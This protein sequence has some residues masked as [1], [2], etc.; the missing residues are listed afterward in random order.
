[1]NIAITHTTT[2]DYS[3]DISESAMEVRLA[4]ASNE[5]QT[6][7]SHQLQVTPRVKLLPYR[8]YFGSTVHFF[9][10]PGHYRRLAVVSTS[11]VETFPTNPFLRLEGGTGQEPLEPLYDYLQFGGPVGRHPELASIAAAFGDERPLLERLTALNQTINRRLD[12][13]PLVT[14]VDSVLD[15]VLALGQGVCQ[16]FAHLMIGVCRELGVPARYVSGYLY[17]PPSAG[18]RGGG[19]SHAWCECYLPGAGWKGFDPT[20]DLLVDDQYVQIATGRDYRDVPPTKGIYRG[21]AQEVIAVS[22]RTE[23]LEPK[24]GGA[25]R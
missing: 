13:R 20:N 2:F 24:R 25:R 17:T 14:Q 16:D 9:T 22:V 5:R 3:D 15:D 12:Y 21:S 6:L 18:A 10:A 7:R 11:V 23:K 19:A 4:P 8:D 1:M